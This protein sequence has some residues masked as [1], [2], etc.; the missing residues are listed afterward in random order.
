M[1]PTVE[2]SNITNSNGLGWDLLEDTLYYIDSATHQVAAF[3]FDSTSGS[4]CMKLFYNILDIK[5]ML[6]IIRE[7]NSFQLTKES[8]LILNKPIT[9]EYLMV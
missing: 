5:Y 7:H 2:L 1:T 9:L 8:Y 4:I 3:D 6:N